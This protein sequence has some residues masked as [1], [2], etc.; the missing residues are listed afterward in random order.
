[1]SRTVIAISSDR[2]D[3]AGALRTRCPHW[4]FSEAGAAWEE[5][6]VCV[7]E[8]G[9][10]APAGSRARIVLDK[11][12]GEP[13]VGEVH[14]SRDVFLAAPRNYLAFALEHAT[15]TEAA[16]RVGREAEYL[17]KVH[18]LMTLIDADDVSRRI[19]ETVLEMVHLQHAALYLHDPRLERYV[20]SF[21]N[22][23]AALDT[24]EFLPGI[25]PETLQNALS[26]ADRLAIDRKANGAGMIVMP[27]QV[28][29]D[30]LGV[31]K[32]SLS[33]EDQVDVRAVT[34]ASRYVR[35]VSQVVSNIY[36]LTRSRDL[37]MLD[38]LTKAFNRRFFESYLDEEIERS[39]RYGAQ[40]SIIFLDLDDLKQV[41]N[42]YGH[43][44][45]SRTLQ[46]VAKQILG[47]VR[48]I[49]K[50]VRFGGDEFC[51][52]LPQ[53]DPE[54][55]MLVANR[56]KRAMTQSPFELEPG[57]EISITASFGI[58]TY[59]THGT[60]KD[61]LI[62]LAD[63][64]MYRVKSTTKNAVGVATLDDVMRPATA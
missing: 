38:D 62:R 52:I 48:T 47:A 40:L 20:V 26:S 10:D 33:R 18:S 46:E 5:S 34:E 19:T 21:S 13:V 43:L 8:G 11:P 56:V 50:V 58:A 61:D 16:E 28:D 39:R 41:N 31:I 51:V 2:S 3:L 45:G 35:A 64:A 60:N 17:R 7:V 32:I 15:A 59:P 53:T 24:G 42:A 44:G 9:K 25:P 23:E 36:Q 49:D 4:D 55:A 30:L 27:L 22:D 12:A 54:Q 6:L 63:A 14:L 29:D 57:V 37:A 1:M